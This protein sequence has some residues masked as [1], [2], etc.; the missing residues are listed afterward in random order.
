M[1]KSFD[2]GDTYVPVY[3][4]RTFDDEI[5]QSPRVVKATKGL[6][7]RSDLKWINSGHGDF[8]TCCR[9][10]TMLCELWSMEHSEWLGRAVAGVVRICAAMTP[11]DGLKTALALSY[12]VACLDGTIDGP[13]LIAWCAVCRVKGGS[14]YDCCSRIEHF[15]ARNLAILVDKSFCRL[16]ATR[17]DDTRL[18]AILRGKEV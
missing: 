17:Y 3:R 1:S 8:E 14:S 7:I 18:K 11:H 9:A 16:D 13:N 10:T 5:L 2:R 15:G 12:D 4:L 6:A